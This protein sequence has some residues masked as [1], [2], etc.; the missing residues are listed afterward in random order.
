MNLTKKMHG[1][2]T[3]QSG[4]LLTMGIDVVDNHSGDMAIGHYRTARF[5]VLDPLQE[6]IEKKITF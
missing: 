1:N 2:Y 4:Y 6:I 5:S 3:I